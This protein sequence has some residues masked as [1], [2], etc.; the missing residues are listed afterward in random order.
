MSYNLYL[1][2]TY[3]RL[4]L[5]VN[6]HYY[7]KSDLVKKFREDFKD[8]C[9]TELLSEFS[10]PLQLDEH[11]KITDDKA[12][13]VSSCL[14]LQLRECCAAWEDN[15]NDLFIQSEKVKMVIWMLQRRLLMQLHTYLYLKPSYIMGESSSY[16]YR[17]KPGRLVIICFLSQY[18]LYREII[19]LTYLLVLWF[20][21]AKSSR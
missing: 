20:D 19:R 3:L 7:R 16:K 1:K 21:R 17:N 13:K 9:L 4:S 18:K 8:G 15:S 5:I 11:N 2:L 6:D 12:K 10:W 14:I